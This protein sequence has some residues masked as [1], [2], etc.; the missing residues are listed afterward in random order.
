MTTVADSIIE[1]IQVSLKFYAS[2]FQA[3]GKQL[4]GLENQECL[5]KIICVLRNSFSSFITTRNE[6]R[7]LIK[8][9]F[10]TDRDYE[11]NHILETTDYLDL[12][13]SGFKLNSQD[14]NIE[15][16]ISFLENNLNS[17]DKDLLFQLLE[18]KARI[19]EL[20]SRDMLEYLR[21]T[22]SINP[23]YSIDYK[24]L[25]EREEEKP[26]FMNQVEELDFGNYEPSKAQK[27]VYEVTQRILAEY[28]SKIETDLSKALRKISL[29]K[30]AH[31]QE[32]VYKI[33]KNFSIDLEIEPS[34]DPLE[35]IDLFINPPE[36]I[37]E[38]N[39]NLLDDYIREWGFYYGKISVQ[40]LKELD[41]HSYNS[42]W[43]GIKRVYQYL[44]DL[45][46]KK[47][48]WLNDER[49][50]AEFN[51]PDLDSIKLE[52][53]NEWYVLERF[54]P[55][56]SVNLQEGTVSS[57]AAPLE[58]WLRVQ[59]YKTFAKTKLIKSR[60]KKL[61]KIDYKH[62][63][64]WL[65]NCFD[66]LDF[67]IS[68]IPRKFLEIEAKAEEMISEDQECGKML[69]TFNRLFSNLQDLTKKEIFESFKLKYSI[70]IEDFNELG[71]LR[72]ILMPRTESLHYGEL[73]DELQSKILFCHQNICQTLERL[74]LNYGSD[75]E[76]PLNCLNKNIGIGAKNAFFSESKLMPTTKLFIELPNNYSNHSEFYSIFE[77]LDLRINSEL[78]DFK[79]GHSLGKNYVNTV[80][81]NFKRD[82]GEDIE[83]DIRMYYFYAA[84][85]ENLI[86]AK[87]YRYVYYQEGEYMD[88][89][90]FTYSQA[91]EV[92]SLDENYQTTK[93]KEI[94]KLGTETLWVD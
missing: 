42:R 43:I 73:A 6:V 39:E 84:L 94:T 52:L 32:I 38:I 54:M 22:Y 74:W 28:G 1:D 86:M 17:E 63:S 58:L 90:N 45:N 10:L 19:Q 34:L 66:I 57:I 69:S 4:L 81:D 30:L 79:F 31:R 61:Y 83:K 5:E 7:V 65:V 67:I 2:E 24:T 12:L 78:I 37:P 85:L 29:N 93:F 26:C 80:V 27:L 14:E 35:S 76:F 48:K 75:I 71:E 68:E 92:A 44:G 49:F 25:K 23:Y 53:E 8:E 91:L 88:T 33:K 64:S 3:V 55:E 20:V 62:N 60:I 41:E 56:C 16:C 50:E 70:I 13:F 46:F 59:K 36:S 51:N 9:K 15:D 40:L 77:Y 72:E 82:Y 89:K 87:T 18:Y 47:S 11:L 21:V